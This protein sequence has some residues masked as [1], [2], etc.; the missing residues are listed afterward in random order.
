[1]I[2]RFSSICPA[3]ARPMAP[4]ALRLNVAPTS[5]ANCSGLMSA[6]P[7]FTA[8]KNSV[9]SSEDPGAPPTLINSSGSAVEMM[10]SKAA[11][12]WA[13]EVNLPKRDSSNGWATLP[14]VWSPAIPL[15][16]SGSVTSGTSASNNAP[17]PGTRPS[18]VSR[19]VSAAPIP[20]SKAAST[21]VS[22]SP[23]SSGDGGW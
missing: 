14:P 22:T 1:M 2:A 10:L 16:A 11:S 20:A 19:R 6:A 12:A 3:L 8:P 18:V 17:P 15:N 13:C 4:A 23:I 7:R 21:T 9:I 5:W